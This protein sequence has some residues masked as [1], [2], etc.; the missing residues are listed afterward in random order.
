MVEAVGLGNEMRGGGGGGGG[1][2]HCG[3][4]TEGEVKRKRKRKEERE[5][6][7]RRENRETLE[8]GSHRL[9]QRLRRRDIERERDR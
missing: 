5:W 1:L 2:E 7:E 4:E 8:R 9:V 3:E 6:R